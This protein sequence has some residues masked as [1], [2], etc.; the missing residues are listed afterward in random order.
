MNRLA[1]QVIAFIVVTVFA[2]GI[3]LSG[4]TLEFEWLRFFAAAVFVATSALVVWDRLLWR[5]GVLQR[6]PG[7]PRPVRGTWEGTLTSLWVDPETGRS[8]DPKTVYL[9][10]RQSASQITVTLLTNETTSR[11]SL[12]QVSETDGV[13]T[14]DYL[15]LDRP[16]PSVRH[17]SPIHHG[18][19]SLT[20]SGRPVTKLMG[21]YWTDR[22]TQGEVEFHARRRALAD[23]YAAAAALFS[24]GPGSGSA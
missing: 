4:D 1:V 11:S 6:L 12:A 17:R 19:G 18:S 10:A 21:R 2:V 13:S 9:V 23:D 5:V 20:V 22:N 16:R 8:P 15:Y 24:G 7:V 3:F 14:L